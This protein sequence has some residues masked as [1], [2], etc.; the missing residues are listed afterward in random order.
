LPTSFEACPSWL[1][2]WFQANNLTIWG[3][4]DLKG[5][6]T[7]EDA[8]GRGFP[9][10]F[11]FAI[12][13]NP[14]IMAGIQ[15]G[16]NR[17]YADE[18]AAVNS[19]INKQAEK[20]AID[21]RSRG[22]RAQPLAASERTDTI[23]IKG[24]FPH[25]TAATL[26]GLGWIG[27]HCQLITRKFGSWI[28]LGTVFTDMILPGGPPSKRS[29]CGRCT[30]CVDVCPAGALKGE[31][32]YPGIPREA[33]LDTEACD[34]WKKEHYFQ[35]HEGHN[36]GICSAV[37]PYGLKVLKEKQDKVYPMFEVRGQK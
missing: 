23:N 26:A 11:S 30:R 35:F 22:F 13:M 5:F 20:L 28:R 3:T 36:C 10:A 19:R 24:I 21:L 7:P 18:Y 31:A 37:C 2:G 25:K 12:A 14:R 27:R 17:A 33:I 9:L 15:H 4:A 29:F 32:W 34:R 1:T 16:P 8:T 6:A